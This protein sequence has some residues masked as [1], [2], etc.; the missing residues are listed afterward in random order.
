MIIEDTEK[1]NKD[2]LKKCLGRMEEDFKRCPNCDLFF[3]ECG[4]DK[5]KNG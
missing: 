5:I 4:G 1:K 2:A 3:C